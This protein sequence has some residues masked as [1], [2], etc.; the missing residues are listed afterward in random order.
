[1]QKPHNFIALDTVLNVLKLKF[2]K[3]ISSLHILLKS[4]IYLDAI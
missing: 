3:T 4:F 1:M 2:G